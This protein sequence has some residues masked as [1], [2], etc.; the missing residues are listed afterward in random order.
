ML[1]NSLQ[2]RLLFGFLG[3]L[4]VLA[5]GSIGLYFLGDGRWS[6]GDCL[7]MTVITLTTVGYAEV[8]PGF[9]EVEHARLFTVFL[10]ILGMGVILYFASTLTAFIIEGDLRRALESTRMRKRLSEIKDHV[11]VCGAGATGRHV[12]AE[13]LLSGTPVVAI[14]SQAHKLE[15]LAKEHG[16][17]GFLYLCGDAT[18]D[19]TL[20]S[21]GL[22]RASGLVAALAND[23]D[24]LYLVVSARQSHPDAERFRIVAR[25]IDLS[26]MTKLRRAGADAVVSPNY[27]GGLRMASE[28]VRPAMVHFIEGMLD[29]DETTRIEEITVPPDSAMVGRTLRDLELRQR[30]NVSVLA[31]KVPGQSGYTYNPGAEQVIEPN[32]LLVVLGTIADVASLRELASRVTSS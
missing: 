9:H 27:L 11:I 10:I 6:L 22:D 8:L 20:A 16:K 3:V 23:K 18:D 24:N 1:T 32:M 30:A 2:K 12:I 26:V 14:D 31:I 4:Q 7:Y 15:E 19:H 25:G 13:L 29:A 5:L 17:A 28:M 21:A